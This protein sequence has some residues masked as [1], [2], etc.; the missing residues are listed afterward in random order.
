MQSEQL[1]DRLNHL[2]V[3]DRIDVNPVGQSRLLDVLANFVHRLDRPLVELVGPEADQL[4]LRF[5]SGRWPRFAIRWIRSHFDSL[6]RIPFIACGRNQDRR[7]CRDY[8]TGNSR[9]R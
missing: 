5:L 4:D 6:S 3:V 1:P 2:R 7:H 9:D 8:A